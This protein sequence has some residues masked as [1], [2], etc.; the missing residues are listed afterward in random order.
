MDLAQSA[1]QI[2]GYKTQPPHIDTSSI[3]CSCTHSLR[4]TYNM[5]TA[6]KTSNNLKAI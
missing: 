1:I 3:N 5:H 6:P 4:H 2:K